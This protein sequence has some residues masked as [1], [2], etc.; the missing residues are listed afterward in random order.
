MSRARQQGEGRLKT[1]F[2][3]FFLVAFVYLAFKVVPAFVNNYELKDAM[4]IEARFASVSRRSE[5]EMRD[6]IYKKIRELELPAS[7]E[8]IRITST[9]LYN[10]QIDLEYTVN[11]E[12][13]GYVLKLNFK[14]SV[15]SRSL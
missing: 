1:I 13:P 5:N 14:P 8:A 2:W 11:V 4:K 3:L 9:G 7:R 12:L 10:V 15:D 6:N